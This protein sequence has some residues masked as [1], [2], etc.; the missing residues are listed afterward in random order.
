MSA[1]DDL[2]AIVVAGLPDNTAE[3]AAR[4][5]K[6]IDGL[7]G[8]RYRATSQRARRVPELGPDMQLRAML[9]WGVEVV[10]RS[11]SAWA[12][13]DSIARRLAETAM[14]LL[15]LL[16]DVK[17]LM[18]GK[19]QMSLLLHTTGLPPAALQRGLQALGWLVD[20]R[21]LAGTTE[22]DGLAW[23]LPMYELFERWGEH[24]RGRD[25]L[26]GIGRGGVGFLPGT[27]DVERRQRPLGAAAHGDPVR[28]GPSGGT[29]ETHAE[30]FNSIIASLDVACP[31]MIGKYGAVD[32]FAASPGFVLGAP[33]GQL[34]WL[35]G[36][37]VRSFKNSVSASGSS[38]PTLRL[39]RCK[40]IT[41]QSYPQIFHTQPP[42]GLQ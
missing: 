27:A 19:S 33:P 14:E 7:F 8:E 34:R 30:R 1:L 11:L 29:N 16:A 22:T 2:T 28:V 37:R 5:E 20:E 9:R 12:A 35:P 21:G 13:V 36:L 17:P 4:T 40:R 15:L 10:H 23:C 25:P 39:P 26:H 6:A 38:V 18:P 31:L 32:Q 42:Q 41:T 3:L 24:H